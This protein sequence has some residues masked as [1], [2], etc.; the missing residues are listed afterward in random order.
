M[1][2]RLYIC[3]GVRA[4]TLNFQT[5]TLSL[6]THSSLSQHTPGPGAPVLPD[7]LVLPASPSPFHPN[8]PSKETT[9]LPGDVFKSPKG[10]FSEDHTLHAGY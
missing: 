2:G 1:S 8:Q 4:G 3:Q 9:L 10:L 7:L 5:Q 6:S